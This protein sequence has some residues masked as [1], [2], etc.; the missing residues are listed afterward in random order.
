MKKIEE[1][2]KAAQ[3]PQQ[4]SK[5]VQ[6]LYNKNGKKRWEHKSKG[7]Y[8][9]RKWKKSNKSPEDQGGAGPLNP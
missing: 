2:V 7:V 1:I 6:N 4:Q 8:S 9:Q 3:K 5:E